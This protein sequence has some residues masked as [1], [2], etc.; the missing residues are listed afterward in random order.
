MSEMFTALAEMLGEVSLGL[1]LENVALFEGDAVPKLGPPLME[2][3]DG[4]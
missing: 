2:E 3:V 1:P 4:R